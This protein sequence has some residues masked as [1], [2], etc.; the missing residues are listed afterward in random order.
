[1][2]RIQ[3]FEFEDFSWFPSGLR[4]GMTNLIAVLHRMMGIS[5]VLA[6][7]IGEVLQEQQVSRIVDL[8]SGSGGPMP[9]VLKIIHEKKELEN[10]ELLL[11]D[12]YPNPQAIKK[13]DR[14]EGDKISYSESPVNA[15]DLKNA[16]DGLL[17]MINSFHHM[18]PKEAR[19]ILASATERGQSILIYEMVENKMPLFLWW[20]LLPLSL[21]ILIIM[22][23]FMTPFVKPLTWRQ[24]FFTYL[25]PVIPICYAWDGQASMPRI[26]ALKD[27]DL[28]LEGLPTDKYVWE[29][30]YPLKK[31]G[32]KLGTYLKG[33]PLKQNF[34][35]S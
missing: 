14:S 21:T 9:E 11:T 25:L 28:L 24:I 18:R 6:D 10:V 15:K 7:C 17:T 19:E 16:P 30:G 2:K 22:V 31:N 29:Q 27:I 23:F 8:G 20:L 13:F 3:L 12:L 1:M 4:N 34:S 26:Y 33:T 5:E 35:G 32:K